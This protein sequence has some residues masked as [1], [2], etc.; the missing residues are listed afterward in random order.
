M[1]ELVLIHAEDDAALVR[2]M[3]ELAVFLSRVSE[4]KLADVAFTLAHGK[5]PA[6]LAIIARDVPELRARLGSAR[7]R[8]VSGAA[9]LADKS[10]TY[11]FRDRLLGA[12]GGKLAFVYSGVMG[13]YPDMMRDLAIAYPECRGAFDELEEALARDGGEFTPSSFIFLRLVSENT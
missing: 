2:R 6:A 7:S 12:E 9:R 5:G 1:T 8:I 10:G 11:W 3:D 13:F 4:V